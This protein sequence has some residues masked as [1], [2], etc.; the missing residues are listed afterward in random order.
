MRI[1]VTGARGML[2]RDLQEEARARGYEVVAAG[3]EDLDIT[4]LGAV[5]R[6]VADVRP[7]CVVNCAAYTDVDGAEA[8]RDK[9]LAVNAL[10]VRNLASVCRERDVELVH[11]STDYV[12]D[13]RKETPYLIFDAPSPLSTY[14]QSKLYGEEYLKLIAPRYYLIRTSWLFGTGGKNFVE[15]VLKL[16]R[17]KRELR[18][19]DDQRGC[20]TYTRDLSR[21]ALD[22]IAT[23]AYGVY[24]V[25][26]AGSTTWCGFAREI[27]RAAGIDVPV[28]PIKSGEL[29]RPAPRPAN[30]ALDPFP[31]Q[32]TLGYLL[33]PWPDALRRYLAEREKGASV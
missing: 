27:L 32:E 28:R 7:A 31:L 6:A 14:G 15:T 24:H 12:F 11:F 33:P 20:P 21:V 10:G 30:S 26:N 23:H 1:L 19:V 25:T 22:L 5:R 4:D 17:E 8:E 16:A 3:R 13:G 2:G 18:V 29:R 9:A